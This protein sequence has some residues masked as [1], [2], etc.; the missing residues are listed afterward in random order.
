MVLEQIKKQFRFIGILLT[1]ISF[2]YIIYIFYHFKIDFSIFQNKSILTYLLIFPA[3]LIICVFYLFISSVIW[4]FILEFISQKKTTQSEIT[5]V[6]F[7]SNLSKY[8]PS[9]IFQLVARN[10][11][12]KKFGWG[13]KEVAITSV[14]EIVLHICFT[15]FLLFC[16]LLFDIK[17]INDH[18]SFLNSFISYRNV[19]ILIGLFILLTVILII[20]WSRFRKNISSFFSSLTK[21]K[22]ILFISKY[23]MFTFLNFLLS[24][25]M[26]IWIFYL[27]SGLPFTIENYIKLIESAVIA[28]FIGYITLGSPGGIG[29]SESIM[30]I[31]LSGYC[32]PASVIVALIIFRLL[33]VIADIF[34]YFISI[35]INK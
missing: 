10:F 4:K 6:Y 31:L 24:N 27:F 25:F 12:S 23:F 33:C 30:V 28:Y 1:I 5:E 22:T 32:N 7:K 16:F 17:F 15:F 13:Q 9:G 19:Y 26:L 14:M 3:I 18:F 8:I 21:R 2:V 11:L 20:L 29:V 34:A 35:L